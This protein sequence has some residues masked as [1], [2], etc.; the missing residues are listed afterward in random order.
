[1]KLAL[2]AT[3][4]GAG[5]FGASLLIQTAYREFSQAAPTG[6][7]SIAPEGRPQGATRQV[8][9]RTAGQLTPNDPLDR[10]RPG[11]RCQ[12]HRVRLQA[13]RTYEIDLHSQEFD[14]YLRIEDA[15]GN[16]LAEDDDGGP[17]LDA[18]LVFTPA[19]AGTYALVVTTFEPDETGSYVL[20]V[21]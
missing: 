11:S 6:G 13:G 17:L 20:S 1:M 14:A 16:G 2:C 21:R 15:A 7:G 10:G 8:P 5:V 19:R 4:L 18:R 3:L 9:F 12:I